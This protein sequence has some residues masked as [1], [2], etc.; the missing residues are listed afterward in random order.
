[1]QKG[2]TGTFLMLV[3]ISFRSFAQD[4]QFSQFYN[5]PTY[6]SPAFAG[7]AH[8]T[9]FTSN[10]RLQWPSLGNGNG[11]SSLSRYTT[12]L[13]AVDSYFSKYRSGVGLQFFRDW[14]AGSTLSTTQVGLQY[15]YELPISPKFTFRPGLEIDYVDR[16]VNYSQLRFPEDFNNQT[17]WNGT[18]EP[19]G[20]RK[21]FADLS[22]GVLFYSDKMWGGFT[23]KHLNTP[24]QSFQ[25]QGTVSKLPMLFDV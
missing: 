17:G 1:M 9:R 13:F 22:S 7:S 6:L 4:I 15:A 14:Q 11:S 16:S 3:L 23:V 5:V 21:Q 18:V 19:G 25:G 8:T 12:S 2:I 24:N 10:N 20:P